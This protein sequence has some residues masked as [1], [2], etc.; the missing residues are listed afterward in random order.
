MCK[1]I[2]KIMMIRTLWG[3]KPLQGY[4]H[5]R[6]VYRLWSDGNNGGHS[7]GEAKPMFYRIPGQ[8]WN[9]AN[10]ECKEYI[11]VNIL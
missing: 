6:T 7:G 10:K 3:L 11:N 2:M 8:A 9:D 4:I 5:L 1:F